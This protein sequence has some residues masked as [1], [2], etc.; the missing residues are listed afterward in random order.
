MHQKSFSIVNLLSFTITAIKIELNM[1]SDQLV[2]KV[3]TFAVHKN[4]TPDK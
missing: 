2:D 4:K 3:T 1:I